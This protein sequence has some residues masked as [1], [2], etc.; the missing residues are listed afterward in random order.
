MKRRGRMM[1]GEQQKEDEKVMKGKR[2][3]ENEGRETKEE[4][5]WKQIRKRS[6]R[7]SGK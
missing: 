3:E 7:G 2:E 5:E 4:S 1:R 6:R